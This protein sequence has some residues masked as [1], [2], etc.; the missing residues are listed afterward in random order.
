MTTIVALWIAT[1]LLLPGRAPAGASA[2]SWV[3]L[4]SPD[5]AVRLELDATGG[6]LNFGDRPG[7]KARDRPL[8]PWADR[9]RRRPWAGAPRSA[10]LEP[11]RVDERYPM[12]GGHSEAVA[13]CNGARI[14]ARHPE[15]GLAY[16]IE[17]RAFDDGVAL[18]ILVPDA[19]RPRVVDEATTFRLVPGST[20][21]SHDLHGHYEGVHAKKEAADLKAGEWAVPP[22]TIRLPDGRGY[23]A[24]TEATLGGFAGMAL[25]VDGRLGLAARLGHAHPASHPF[26]LRY[27]DDVDR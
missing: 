10:R 24:I 18:R 8:G 19:G 9:G 11:Y 5:G 7:R 20:V 14:P 13:R 6:R 22:L 2:G 26:T 16:T 4:A 17:A 23:A 15:S 25:Q 27:K 3:E 21:W 1:G 12:R